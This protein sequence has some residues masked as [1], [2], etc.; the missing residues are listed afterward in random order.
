MT[1]KSI[2]TSLPSKEEGWVGHGA[3]ELCRVLLSQSNKCLATRASTQ[4]RRFVHR[5]VRPDVRGEQR[6]LHLQLL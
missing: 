4:R 3:V 6:M 5:D 1:L 2:E